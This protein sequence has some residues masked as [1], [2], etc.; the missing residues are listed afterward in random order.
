MVI[1]EDTSLSDMEVC[2]IE[3]CLSLPGPR[4]SVVSELPRA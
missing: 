2:D 3:D 4:E 1:W